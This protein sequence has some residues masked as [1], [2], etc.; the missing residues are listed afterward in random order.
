MIWNRE[1]KIRK[2]TSAWKNIDLLHYDVQP[3]RNEELFGEGCSVHELAKVIKKLVP[4]PATKAHS[5][6]DWKGVFKHAF[7][8][9]SAIYD[10]AEG[11]QLRKMA[12]RFAVS[13]PSLLFEK[14]LWDGSKLYQRH[15]TIMWRAVYDIFG[16]PWTVG[17]YRDKKRSAI[18]VDETIM[19]EDDNKKGESKPIEVDDDKPTTTVTNEKKPGEEAD[20][21]ME[22]TSET[23]GERD[24]ADKSEENKETEDIEIPTKLFL[25]K[26]LFQKNKKTKFNL[27]N[28]ENKR[29]FE[30]F[31]KC[32]LPRIT[33]ESVLEGN[34]ELMEYFHILLRQIF[35]LDASAIILPWNVDSQT[36]PLKKN[37]KLPETRELMDFYVD[38][39]FVKMGKENWS[40]MQIAHDK[41]VEHISADTTWFRRQGMYFGAD[42]IQVKRHSAAGWFLGSHPAMVCKDLKQAIQRHPAMKG[43][44]LAIKFQNIR[45]Q[46][47]GSVDFKDQVRAAHIITDY[48]RVSEMRSAI[49]K[50]YD[51]P[52]ELGYPLGI[53]LRFVPN[54]AD[55]RY[56]GGA[57][58]RINCKKLRRKQ[59]NFLMNTT[60][61]DSIALQFIDF[62]LKDVGTLRSIV[63]KFETEASTPKKPKNLFISVE[64]NKFSDKVT[65]IYRREN[66]D[67]AS[68]TISALPLILEAY[69]GTRSGNWLA[70]D[71]RS[72]CIGWEF[73]KETEMITSKE[74]EYTAA[75]LKGWGEDSD[76]E[77]QNEQAVQVIFGS[78]N[79][80]NQF[81]DNGTVLTI[82]SELSGWSSA[83]N[84]AATVEKVAKRMHKL[85]AT[86]LSEEEKQKLRNILDGKTPSEEAEGDET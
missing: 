35:K 79:G 32:K 2:P 65:F 27:V 42:E 46:V 56:K 51:N 5:V 82:D 47:E 8:K 33:K 43:L 75:L 19:N 22:D 6:T 20:R 58:T 72:E 23:S 86:D 62:H 77:D 50:I 17:T 63:M 9:D 85:M 74:D 30:T 76:D 55:S 4:L 69:Y 54:I 44:P 3:F 36:P 41:Q 49:K 48:N 29:Q 15:D 83:S 14:D 13:D 28:P 71:W 40:R 39:T 81:D 10:E 80:K 67:Q 53:V 11:E 16:A 57:A 26:P 52:G 61:Q 59:K 25:S 64:E 66:E 34:I 1:E 12:V 70:P 31:Y 18:E 38:R 45:L 24:K 21:G 73:N 7:Q 37:S 78:N 84:D 60:I 68:T